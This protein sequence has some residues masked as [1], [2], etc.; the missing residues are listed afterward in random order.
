MPPESEAI[1][2][3]SKSS[4]QELYRTILEVCRE[5]KALFGEEQAAVAPV[6]ENAP[7]LARYKQSM[8]AGLNRL[9][10]K[11]ERTLGG[12]DRD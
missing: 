5:V 8:E 7:E 6:E 10:G 4:E 11:L 3:G 1:P 2:G 9:Q 12:S